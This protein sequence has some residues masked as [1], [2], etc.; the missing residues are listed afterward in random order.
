MLTILFSG[1]DK[2]GMPLNHVSSTRVCVLH[3]C[4]YWGS[5]LLQTHSFCFTSACIQ[6][7]RVLMSTIL[8]SE[9]GA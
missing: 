2:P 1:K 8:L 5:F 6:A 9:L 3:F 4:E 7:L